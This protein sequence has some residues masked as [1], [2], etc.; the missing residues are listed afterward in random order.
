M[1]NVSLSVPHHKQEHEYSCVAACVRMVLAYHGHVVSEADLRQL[2]G[3]QASGTP[4]RDVMRVASLGFDVQLAP[5]NLALLAAALGAGTPPI[6]FVQ[7]GPLDYWKVDCAH[8]AVL[9]GLEDAAVCLND[10]Y[11]DT[12]P[13]RTSLASFQQAWAAVG[14]DAAL[15]RPRQ[16]QASP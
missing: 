12:A 13:Q 16:T 3:T 4:A 10:P 2:L 14:H 8:V 1:P 7:T 15:I 5:S 11:F 9:V 6:V